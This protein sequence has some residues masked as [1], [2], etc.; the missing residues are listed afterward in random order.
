L[1]FLDY[2][3]PPTANDTEILRVVIRESM[4]ADLLERLIGDIV[5]VTERLVESDPVDLSNLQTEA[6]HTR[7]QRHQRH[8]RQSKAHEQKNSGKDRMKSMGQGVHKTVC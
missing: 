4:S 7:I 8:Q 6:H 1:T 5:A 3:L 2:P